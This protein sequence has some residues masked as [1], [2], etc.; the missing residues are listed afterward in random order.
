ARCV[1]RARSLAARGLRALRDDRAVRDVCRRGDRRAHPARGL[2]GAGG[3][4]RRRRVGPRV[5]RRAPR[6]ASAQVAP[7]GAAFGERDLAAGV[8][9][10]AARAAGVTFPPRGGG[11]M[12]LAETAKALVAP[13]KGILA[14]DES[15][16]TN[17]RRFESIGV[18]NS[19]DN[20]RAYRELL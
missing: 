12:D 7:R 5:V 20:R 6:A 9:R 10:G 19:E 16:G 2:R 17:K 4:D 8:L 18:E 13:G 1:G 11:P 14:A 3:E 15:T